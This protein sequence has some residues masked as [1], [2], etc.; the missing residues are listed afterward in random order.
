MLLRIIQ[1]C[2]ILYVIALTLL[3]ELPNPQR[4]LLHLDAMEPTEGYKHLI[5]FTL[6]GFLVELSR[7][8]RTVFFWVGILALYAIG[9][10]ILQGLLNPIFHRT[11]D[12]LD[13]MQDIF[14]ILLGTGIGYCCRFLMY[15]FLKLP[16]VL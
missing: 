9:T 13:I 6:L 2:T 14:G 7:R 8:K 15:R 16:L 5:A 11:F 4:F 1:W 10:E 3:L 12:F